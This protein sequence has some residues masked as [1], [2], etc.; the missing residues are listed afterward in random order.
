MNASIHRHTITIK[1]AYGRIY[2]TKAQALQD[3]DEGKDFKDMMTGAY[4]SCR[5]RAYMYDTLKTKW[6]DVRLFDGSYF[7]IQL[8]E[9][10]V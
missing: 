5:D 4:L 9:G 10:T 2:H 8:S 3:W 7:A 6:I 1:G